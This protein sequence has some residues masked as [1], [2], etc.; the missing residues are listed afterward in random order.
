MY[1]STFTKSSEPGVTMAALSH[2]DSEIPRGTW[3]KEIVA[4]NDSILRQFNIV[5]IPAILLC[6]SK[7]ISV[8]F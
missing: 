6:D 2:R 7:T 5:S 8:C 1:L 4:L 3:G